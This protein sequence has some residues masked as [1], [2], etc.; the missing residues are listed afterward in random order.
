[1]NMAEYYELEYSLPQSNG[2]D[3][4]DWSLGYSSTM[5]PIVRDGDLWRMNNAEGIELGVAFQRDNRIYI[6][7]QYLSCGPRHCWFAT[8]LLGI[9]LDMRASVSVRPST[10]QMYVAAQKASPDRQD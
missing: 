8:Q 7:W 6:E 1:M 4:E 9:M 3:L 2:F 5:F 10:K